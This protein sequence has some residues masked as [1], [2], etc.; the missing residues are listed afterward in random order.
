MGVDGEGAFGSAVESGG[1]LEQGADGAKQGEEPHQQGGMHDMF[2]EVFLLSKEAQPKKHRAQIGWNE[3]G[4]MDRP[5]E[6]E[7]A[8][9]D[10]DIETRE[11]EGNFW[12]S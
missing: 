12:H 3:G 5:G 6:E 4:F 9:A 8:E 11:D 10:C 1:E 2:A 7:G